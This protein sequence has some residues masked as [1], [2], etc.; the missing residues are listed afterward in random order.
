MV[1]T[2]TPQPPSNAQPD[3]QLWRD[4]GLALLLAVLY[5]LLSL[6]SDHIA[7]GRPPFPIW[8]SDGMAL[9][10]WFATR[11]RLRW[12]QAVAVFAGTMASAL[13]VNMSWE[14]AWIAS[15]ANVLQ[16]VAG[17][18]VINA[19]RTHVDESWS[20][21]RR[22]VWFIFGVVGIVNGVSATLSAYAFTTGTN[23]P[24]LYAMV[25]TFIADGLGLLLLMPL[26][27]V[28][29]DRAT[30]IMMLST[31]AAR[32]EAL[33]VFLAL[34]VTSYQIFSLQPDAFGLVPPVF[35]LGVPIV[36]WAAVRFELRGATLALTI[37]ALIAFYYTLRDLGPFSAG[38][39][40]TSK[41][42][43]QLQGYL[44][45]LIV[46]TLVASALIR[47]RRTANI[48]SLAWRRRYETALK[49]S[50]NVVF[51]IDYLTGTI[52]WA[53]DTMSAL[54]IVA[55]TITTTRAWTERIH[56]DDLGIV[57]AIRE[58]LAS[59][60][61]ANAELT[62]RVRRDDGQ[63]TSLGVTVFGTESPATDVN[64]E[65]VGGRRTIGFVKDI[66]EK[67]RAADERAKLEAELRQAQKMEA[68]GQLAGG[69]AH[70]FNNILSAIL[71]YGEMARQRAHEPVLQQQLDTIVK[72]GERGRVLVA[73][74]L[75]FS[76]K[77]AAE[78]ATLAAADLL[79]EVV[80]LVKGSN[81]H[82]IVL[83]VPQGQSFNIVGNAT[84]LHQ[85]FM[86]VMMNGVQA[87]AE[88]GRLDVDIRQ[89]QLAAPMTVMQG[90][91]PVGAYI[92][93]RITDHGVG[94]DAA[95]R[96]RM[97]EPFF[98]TKSLGR[99]TGLGLSLA[100]SIAKAHRGGID[101]ESEV[102]RGTTFTIY[103]PA[104]DAYAVERVIAASIP[105]GNG[106]RILLVDDEVPLRELA[107]E[108]L[109]ELGYETAG[110]STS[111]DALD[112]YLKDPRRFDAVLSDE[113]MPGLTGTQLATR[114]H[115][116]NPQLPVLIITAYGGAG[117]ELRAQ[118]AGVVAVLKKPYDK[119]AI[120]Q[121]LASALVTSR[122][123]IR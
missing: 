91:L 25:T 24:F 34:I 102:G 41:S 50:N 61:I 107:E 37:Y 57:L 9:G 69:I 105:R 86:N 11:A 42:V 85:L 112:A 49:A 55:A 84:E 48:E 23:A 52:G 88:G 74:I 22:F 51:E 35:Y 19:G 70:D 44:T 43:L 100:M 15:A 95:T 90:Q 59:G 36:L 97:F 109:V 58:K 83:D 6:V 92:A 119:A 94:I 104:R 82:D 27:I 56:P 76:R 2:P 108:I 123:G 114:I 68:I 121:A 54:G 1:S 18:A 62:Y 66:T 40:P 14:T 80:T 120:A 115:Q 106:E 72:A 32:A 7:A 118:Q 60:A 113:V 65:R 45:V 30:P 17:V 31:T 110:Y 21:L 5:W 87:M 122:T 93:V 3:R 99:G 81:P 53:G 64:G 16:L 20:G 78:T 10:F 103:L 71:G 33:L 4:L 12:P 63:Y 38:F 13:G 98:T 39:V 89:L 117:F 46:S 79:D 29:S 75:T 8:L 28:W 77:N 67:L 116:D 101:V 26:I 96:E 47:E 73:Q 111:Q